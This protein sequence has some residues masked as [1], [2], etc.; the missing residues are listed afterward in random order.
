[1]SDFIEDSPFRK[2]TGTDSAVLKV[3]IAENIA[4]GLGSVA[5]GVQTK[6]IGNGSHTEGLG[7]IANNGAEHAFGVYN[8]SNKESDTFYSAGNT[9][10]SIGMGFGED[11]RENAVEVMQNSDVYL[12]GIGDYDGTNP[13]DA[14][15]LKEV[16]DSKADSADLNDYVTKINN[17]FAVGSG[18]QSAFQKNPE[19]PNTAS[20]NSSV[21]IGAD[22][23]ATK[24]GSFAANR[25][26]HAIGDDS[27]ATGYGNTA[28]GDTSHAEG[29]YTTASGKYSHTEGHGTTASNDGTHA[30][31]WS[32]KATG[33]TSHAEGHGSVAGGP[34]SHAEGKYTQTSNDS[35]HA[36][37]M[38]NKSNTGTIHSIGI[39]TSDTNRKNAFEIMENGDAYLF[40]IGGYNG[41]NPESTN[42]LQQ[43]L[44]S[45]ITKTVSDLTNY[46]TKSQ[47]Y[48]KEEVMTQIT[49]AI[50]GSFVVV[51]LLPTASADTLGKIYLIPSTDAQVQNIKDEYITI[52]NGGAYSWEKIG[53]T[54]IDLSGYATEQYVDEK[55][56]AKYTKPVSGVPA[57]DLAAGVI[58]EEATNAEVDALFE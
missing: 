33:D 30:E 42:T 31:G 26:N 2:G 40:G 23:E 17:P 43:I 8:K 54:S 56:A 27:N 11:S 7:T 20:G 53:S 57:S 16:I 18:I 35:E 52:E 12:R 24:I 49:N 37:G 28:S 6:A 15:T 3:N 58:P 55:V 5:E 9:L 25:K 1:M 51:T 36:Q 50:K 32:S 47:T 41:T 39:G 19:H 22:N 45:F 38:Y 10:F 14:K 21:A 34:R 46:Y 44:D 13:E 29:H 4:L 48:T